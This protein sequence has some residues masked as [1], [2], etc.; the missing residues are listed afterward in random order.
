MSKRATLFYLNQ[1]NVVGEPYIVNMAT[2]DNYRP[3]FKTPGTSREELGIPKIDKHTAW[4]LKE[5]HS[6]GDAVSWADIE[7][8]KGFAHRGFVMPTPEQL[9]ELGLIRPA[10]WKPTFRKNNRMTQRDRDAYDAR[11]K[12]QH[13]VLTPLGLTTLTHWEHWSA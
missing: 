6:R 1:K 3:P 7:R 10:K 8:S 2:G 11:L 12:E 9:I 4:V 13:Y 5:I